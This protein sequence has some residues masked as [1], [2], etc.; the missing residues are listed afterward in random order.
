[1]CLFPNPLFQTT[2]LTCRFS[3]L[4]PALGKP[5]WMQD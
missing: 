4:E 5:F 3:S 1:L 2:I